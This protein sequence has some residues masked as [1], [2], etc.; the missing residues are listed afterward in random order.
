[1]QLRVETDE[2]G[3]ELEQLTKAKVSEAQIEW[4]LILASH[5]AYNMIQ[6][7]C[8]AHNVCQLAESTARAVTGGRMMAGLESSSKISE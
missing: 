4:I 2:L 6:K 1:M 5:L 8:N 3:G 7:N